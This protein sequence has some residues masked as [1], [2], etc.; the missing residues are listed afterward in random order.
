MRIDKTVSSTCWVNGRILIFRSFRL[1][2][3][4]EIPRSRDKW[5]RTD[6][7]VIFDVTLKNIYNY[8]II[9]VIDN[10]IFPKR[11]DFMLF[12]YVFS[13]VFTWSFGIIFS[14]ANHVV[15]TSYKKIDRSFVYKFVRTPLNG[16]VFKSKFRTI[17][18]RGQ[19]R[20]TDGRSG[21]W[22]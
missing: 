11:S 20:Q 18:C 19:S 4:S 3:V 1:N 14:T 2:R 15:I 6:D 22:K 21:L 7:H 17:F 9:T 13:Y 12:R 8:F 16:F 10:N 5:R